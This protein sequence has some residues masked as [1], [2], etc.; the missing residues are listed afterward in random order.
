M[1][2]VG[3]IK[4]RGNRTVVMNRDGEFEASIP[5]SEVREFINGYF[6]KWNV[7]RSIHENGDEYVFTSYEDFIRA[8][9]YILL[10]KGRV[11]KEEAAKTALLLKI[12]EVDAV[13]G[14]LFL[15]LYIARSNGDEDAYR[16]A[17][18]IYVDIAK[19]YARLAGL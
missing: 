19:T 16:R 8:A 6:L 18:E 14:G 11:P 2:P 1:T 9:Y 7:G 13:V 10:R 17:V 4:K 3:S 12:N 15:R 5:F